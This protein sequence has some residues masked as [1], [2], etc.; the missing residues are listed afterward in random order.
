MMP[1]RTNLSTSSAQQEAKPLERVEF[2]VL[3]DTNARPV[4]D[5]CRKQ[6]VGRKNRDLIWR[7]VPPPVFSSSCVSPFQDA[8]SVLVCSGMCNGGEGTE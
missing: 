4:W 7:V 8:F 1:E 3:Q 2:A 5:Y 6:L